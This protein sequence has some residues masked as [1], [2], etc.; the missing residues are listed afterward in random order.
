ME[1]KAA[2]TMEYNI[3]FELWQEFVPSSLSDATRINLLINI[4]QRKMYK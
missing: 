4:Y 3:Q 1:N 2:N